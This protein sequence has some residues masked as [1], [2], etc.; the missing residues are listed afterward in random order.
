M[1]CSTAH[2]TMTLATPIP[3]RSGPLCWA[4]KI[5]SA[6]AQDADHCTQNQDQIADRAGRVLALSQS[7][8]LLGL[9]RPDRCPR[10]DQE[11]RAGHDPGHEATNHPAE[12]EGQADPDE[13]AST[14]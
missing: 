6:T 13:G 12:G 11:D 9:H 3:S 10:P 7:R 5:T 2:E 4:R 14:D 1:V 8:R